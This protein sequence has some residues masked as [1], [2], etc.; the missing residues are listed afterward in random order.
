[1]KKCRESGFDLEEREK[2]SEKGKDRKKKQQNVEELWKRA[3]RIAFTI[4]VRKLVMSLLML[5]GIGRCIQHNRRAIAVN[6]F[7]IVFLIIY[8]T[9][10][11][12]VFLNF[13]FEY[14]QYMKQNAT[15]EKRICIESLLNREKRLRL[16]RASDVAAMIAER[17]LTEKSSGRR[18]E[19]LAT[20]KTLERL[21]D[22]SLR[23]D[24]WFRRR[25]Q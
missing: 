17:C 5:F 21:S 25:Q 20:E 10:G 16:T 2:E 12:F 3:I 4:R 6:G 11:G 24:E 1:M 19:E 23:H 7:I 15:L 13:E 8:T 14:Q 18:S 22:I 9:I